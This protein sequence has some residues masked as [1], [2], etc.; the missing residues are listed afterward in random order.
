MPGING[1]CGSQKTSTIVVDEI[2][3]SPLCIMDEISDGSRASLQPR[4]PSFQELGDLSAWLATQMDG[5][6]A[7]FLL[8][9]TYVAVFDDYATDCPGYA[10]KLM[11]VVWGGSPTMYDVFTWHGEELVQQSREN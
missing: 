9:N 6:N 5:D 2:T 4:A 10:G 8:E 11:S 3:L 7:R 1:C